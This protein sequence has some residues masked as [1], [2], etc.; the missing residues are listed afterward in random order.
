[1]NNDKKPVFFKK[2][3]V[4]A[5]GEDGLTAEESNSLRKD[6]TK[7]GTF[8]SNNFER[9]EMSNYIKRG[10][11]GNGRLGFGKYGDKSLEW[12]YNHDRSYF[13]WCIK[14]GAVKLKS[15]IAFD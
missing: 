9:K 5:V 8:D 15:N 10:S 7:F 2:R 12:V 11:L 4:S 3:I 6:Y 13:N 1:M 14:S